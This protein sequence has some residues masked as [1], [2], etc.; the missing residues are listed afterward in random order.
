MYGIKYVHKNNNNNLSGLFCKKIE[1]KDLLIEYT[2]A[3]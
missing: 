1:M 3:I 2:C